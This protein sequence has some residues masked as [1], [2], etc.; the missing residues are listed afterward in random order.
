[1]TQSTWMIYGATGYSG[2]LIAEQAQRQG[3]QPVIAGR[4]EAKVAAL[5]DALD[6]P[7]RVFS[8]QDGEAVRRGLKGVKVLLN[9]AGP[10]SATARELMGACIELGV[11][12]ADITGEIEVFEL[13]A[14]LNDAARDGGVVLCPGVGFDV[15]PTDCMAAKLHQLMPDATQLAL[16][17][18]S[19]SGFSPGT[20]KTSVEG[21]AKGGCVRR[22]GRLERVPLGYKTRRIDFG[23]GEKLAMTIPWG[24]VST[25]YRSTGIDNIEVYIPAS[26]GLVKRLR[27]LNYLRWLLRLSV[28]QRW[29]KKRVD[30]TVRGP[31]E[32]QRAQLTTAVWGEVRNAAGAVKTGRIQVANGYELTVTGSLAMVELLLHNP[33]A[34]G[35]HYTPT[36]LADADLIT[37]LPGSGAFSF[38]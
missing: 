37:R 15:I 33:P 18:D 21:L 28:V 12:Y 32:D 10:F 23:A 17:F 19:R 26:P 7:A 5:A 9:C 16:G 3:L 30:K 36:L 34:Q 35:G 27:K 13:A 25:A 22:D 4:S 6:L 2:R 14:S 1:M 11:H 29:M 24:D 38:A 20:A 31:N 8:V